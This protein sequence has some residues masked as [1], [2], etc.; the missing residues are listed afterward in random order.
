[1]KRQPVTT[2]RRTIAEITAMIADA[3]FYGNGS[4]MMDAQA[5]LLAALDVILSENFPSDT[6]IEHARRVVTHADSAIEDGK[7]QGHARIAD[8]FVLVAARQAGE[9]AK[10]AS[11]L[12]RY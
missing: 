11:H 6:P 5:E 3:A 1:M 2:T 12:A 4:T 8:Y 9:A 10:K 7:A